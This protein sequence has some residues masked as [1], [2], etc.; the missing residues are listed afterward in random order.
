MQK[1]GCGF[2]SWRGTDGPKQFVWVAKNAVLRR[3]YY[4]K[5]QTYIQACA[6]K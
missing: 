5:E 4:K 2:L 3:A 1:N 6:K